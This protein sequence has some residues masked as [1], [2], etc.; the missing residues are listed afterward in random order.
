MPPVNQLYTELR[1]RGLE[2]R[3]VTFREQEETVRKVVRER[4]YTAPVLL[5]ASGDTSGRLWGV[6]GPPT[7]YLVDRQ[8]RLA[9]RIVGER[10]WQGPGARASIDALLAGR[11]LP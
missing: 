7:A 4:G 11:P 1:R 8:G 5:D 9:A 6:F 10:D 2:V 3:L